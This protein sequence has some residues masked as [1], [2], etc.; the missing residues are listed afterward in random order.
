MSPADLA[1]RAG[2]AECKY[3]YQRAVDGSDPEALLD[4]FTEDAVIHHVGGR[5][6]MEG[7]DEYAVWCRERTE[8]EMASMHMAMNPILEVDGDEA[9]GRWMYLVFLEDDGT[10]EFG[11]GEYDDEYRRVD[12]EWKYTHLGI[13]R[14][15]T[16]DLSD[17]DFRMGRG[18]SLADLR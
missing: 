18:D 9:A 10:L 8:T 1:A 11:Q 12:G 7:R 2:V 4:C 15:L 14:T 3:R 5:G 17:V 16:M 6:R 13:R